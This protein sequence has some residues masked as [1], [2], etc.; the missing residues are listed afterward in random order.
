MKHYRIT[1]NGKTYDV[2]VED[3]AVSAPSISKALSSKQETAAPPQPAAPTV[4]PQPAA[5]TTRIT[6]LRGGNDRCR[7]NARD[8]HCI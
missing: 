8:S 2:T 5:P 4:A 3:L 7:S 6:T 1:V